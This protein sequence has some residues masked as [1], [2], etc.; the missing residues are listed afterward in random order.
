MTHLYF[1]GFDCLGCRA[2]YAP[3]QDLLLC[4]RCH[5]LLAEAERI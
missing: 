5:Q 3:D 4:P 1:T 2:A